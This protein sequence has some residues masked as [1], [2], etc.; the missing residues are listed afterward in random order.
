M[1]RPALLYLYWGTAYSASRAMAKIVGPTVL[2]PWKS[3]ADAVYRD[4]ADTGPGDTL[5]LLLSTSLSG[6]VTRVDSLPVNVSG[7]GQA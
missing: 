1:R 4:G 6:F 5:Q 7:S 3:M 2:F